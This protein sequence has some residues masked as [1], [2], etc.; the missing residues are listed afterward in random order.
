MVY[1]KKHDRHHNMGVDQ[2]GCWR[3]EA[4]HSHLHDGR[5]RDQQH[6]MAGLWVCMRLELGNTGQEQ[7]WG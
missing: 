1:V 6:R 4:R 3:A 2:R 7:G 5:C